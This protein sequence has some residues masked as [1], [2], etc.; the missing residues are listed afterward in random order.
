MC[1][2][3]KDCSGDGKDARN[4]SKYFMVQHAR[5]TNYLAIGQRKFVDFHIQLRWILAFYRR[6][7]R[8]RAGV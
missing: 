7:R 4:V 6:Q 8:I 3:G 2:Q 1:R 5:I